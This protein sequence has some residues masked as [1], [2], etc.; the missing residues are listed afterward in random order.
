MSQQNEWIDICSNDDLVADTGICALH[1]GEQV[2]IFKVSQTGQLFAVQNYCPFGEANVISR[3]LI[4]SVGDDMAVA[5]PL[6]KQRFNLQ[7]GQ[8]LDDESCQLK[9]FPVRLEEGVIQLRKA[10]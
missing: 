8:C 5:S 4:A 6:Y 3:G 10:G 2:A 7:T 1:E 9:T